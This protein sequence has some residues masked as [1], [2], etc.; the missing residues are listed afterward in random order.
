MPDMDEISEG[1]VFAML[2]D[3]E[4][5]EN[6]RLSTIIK[7]T[8]SNQMT[9]EDPQIDEEID[10]MNETTESVK[11]YSFFNENENEISKIGRKT[12]V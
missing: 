3:A 2:Q 12:V 5:A 8:T 7:D 6:M 10:D 11:P 1:G 9:E 4:N